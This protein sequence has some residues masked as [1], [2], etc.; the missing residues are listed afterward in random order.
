MAR[1]IAEA[2]VEGSGRGTIA[3]RVPVVTTL[4][5]SI[6]DRAAPLLAS[7]SEAVT[8]AEWLDS[9]DSPEY[10]ELFQGMLVVPPAPDT[11]HQ[12]IAT[13]MSAALVVRTLLEGGLVL[14]APTAVLLGPDIGFE[15][16]ILYLAP[17]HLARRSRRAVDGPPDIVV[18][19]ASPSTRAYD[20]GTKLPL[21]LSHG[22]REVWIVDPVALTV[23]VY[24]PGAAAPKVVRFGERIPSGIV[25]V[26][27][28][29]LDRLAP[30]R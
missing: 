17:E 24:E 15:P 16:D 2:A 3:R 18:E 7:R 12:D 6:I 20:I 21:Y 25:D 26:G 19:V 30:P 23:S 13:K 9:P 1:I 27:A 22:V 14:S 11:G 8:V 29:N 4:P 10:S 28:A 5:R